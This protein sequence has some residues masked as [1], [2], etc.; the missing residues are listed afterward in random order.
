MDH[1]SSLPNP[2]LIS[3]ANKRYR[4]RDCKDAIMSRYQ[5][6]ERDD[7]QIVEI[8]HYHAEL[9][10]IRY[11]RLIARGKQV[12]DVCDTQSMLFR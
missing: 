8:E 7:A 2:E 10:H 9:P 5:F 11:F 12:T 3:E 6:G 1:P 4:A